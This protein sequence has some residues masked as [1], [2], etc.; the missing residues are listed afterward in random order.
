MAAHGSDERVQRLRD[1]LTP[2]AFLGGTVLKTHDP[3]II[4]QVFNFNGLF[5]VKTPKKPSGFQL[6]A[7]NTSLNF[8]NNIQGHFG[9]TE[10]DTHTH[11]IFFSTD[12]RSFMF[13]IHFL[14]F[15]TRVSKFESA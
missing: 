11:Q 6:G 12:V 2:A 3:G 1:V 8:P 9:R 14:K 4:P 13:G 5:E 15:D 7:A 10:D